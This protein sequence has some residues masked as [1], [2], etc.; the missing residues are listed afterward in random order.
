MGRDAQIEINTCAVSAE[1]LLNAQV[2]GWRKGQA[3]NAPSAIQAEVRV[4]PRFCLASAKG[5]P[6][7][8]IAQRRRCSANGSSWRGPDPVG[9][10]HRA[11]IAVGD[12]VRGQATIMGYADCFALPGAVMIVAILPV[13]LLKKGTGSGGPAH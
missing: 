8:T 9:A 2:A 7:P 13:A 12:T 4:W 6:S 3:P 1:P 10:L 5:S 11:D